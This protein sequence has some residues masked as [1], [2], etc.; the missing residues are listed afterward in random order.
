MTANLNLM[1]NRFALTVIAM[2][3]LR[4][5]DVHVTKV[6]TNHRAWGTCVITTITAA[7]GD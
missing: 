5:A 6:N 3:K 2:L 7:L 4:D 1:K